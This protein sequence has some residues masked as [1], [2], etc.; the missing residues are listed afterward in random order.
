MNPE[1][2]AQLCSDFGLGS[3]PVVE[4]NHDGVLN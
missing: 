3:D 2:L 4:E 1:H